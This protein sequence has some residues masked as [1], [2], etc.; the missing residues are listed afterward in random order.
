MDI[1]FIHAGLAAGAALAALPVILHLFMRQ[2]PKHVI[3]PALRLIRERQK[4]SRKKLR[5][6][7][8]LLLLARMAVISLMAL[9]LARP[10]IYSQTSLGD[11]EVPTAL[12][13]VFDTSLSMGYRERDKT[14]LDEAK[15]RA[16]DILK[17]TPDSSQVF[18]VDSA[19]PGVPIG[20]SPA[21]ARKR[22]E[23][24]TLRATSYP[25]NTALGLVYSAVADSERPRHEV[26][27]LTDL[28]RSAW[29]RNSKID[30]LDKIQKVK[31]GVATYVLK[32][33]PEE[34]RDVAIVEAEPTSRVVS[35]GDSV[36]IQVK[37]R[38]RGP[39]T[40]RLV[41]LFFNAD[42]DETT[43]KEQGSTKKEIKKGQQQ[44][45]IQP[46]GESECRFLL[47][48]LP[49]GSDLHQGHVHIGGGTDPL[50]ADDDRYFTFK[51]Q[52]APKVLLV[53]DL[54]IDSE[55]V[56]L[57]IDPNPTGSE[58]GT[59][60][61][62]HA[63]RLTTEQFESRSDE[64]MKDCA[65]IFLLNVERLGETTWERLNR[66]V[67]DGG[68]L[69]VG[70]GHRP[71]PANYNGQAASQLLPATLGQRQ[72]PKPLMTNFGKVTDY[73]H[74]L[75]RRF[76]K[77]MDPVLSQVPVY[78]YWSI[79]KPEDS[80]VLM[81]FADSH[82]ALVERTFHGPKAGRVLLWTTPLSRRS[83]RDLN[84]DF[85]W[86]EFPLPDYWPFYAIMLQTVPYL[87]G[88]SS[89][90]LTEEAGEDVVLPV[91]PL[92]RFKNYAVQG[93]NDRSVDRLSPPVTSDSLVIVAPQA[94]GHWTVT[95]TGSNGERMK[96]GFSINPPPKEF[97][98][99]PLEARDL[100]QLFGSRQGYV[101]ADDPESLQRAVQK[102]RVGQEMFPWLM[103]LI[104][105]VVTAENVLANRFYRESGKTQQQ[106][107]GAAA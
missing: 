6:R 61:F 97:D 31:T 33:T 79:T 56:A 34:I 60:R 1:S 49:A 84:P 82:P 40:T 69:V 54:A 35:A 9:A 22:I 57:A 13:L 8:W 86:N 23:G 52:P 71:T 46:N 95:A 51:V 83:D 39:A 4:R 43:A 85:A 24:L 81:E 19:E 99:A 42:G 92:R 10:R 2:T 44:V 64:V 17:K 94:V 88:T 14:R 89:E 91:D 62:C 105:I 73:T 36:E 74:P 16:F 15:E 106:A 7:N 27:V 20:L 18:V 75:F 29:D 38:S 21:A 104:L 26:Y 5:I 37:L 90:R 65:C 68:G 66:Y 53:S 77:E 45:Q 78:H 41:E 87:A 101:L 96:T 28:A 80:R 76:G 93:P 55:F 48:K 30:G 58:A 70:L 47:P 32:L 11:Q 67:H 63:E 72:D 3:F 103:A 107:V 59:P 50:V 102:G 98:F 25:L 100:D 12:G